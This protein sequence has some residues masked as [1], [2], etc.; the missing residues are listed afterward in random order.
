MV[1]PG[2]YTVRF[3][4]DGKTVSQPLVVK[5][6]PRDAWTQAQYQAGYDFAKKYS[7]AYGQIDRVLNNLD[8]IGKSLNAAAAA[9]AK[10]GNQTLASQIAALQKQRDEVF[11]TFTADYHNDEDSIQ[12]PGQ[13]REEV[14]RTGFGAQT[15][16]TAAQ[17]DYAGRF[18]AAYR[19]AF[20]RYNA[21]VTQIGSS[22]VK[23]MEGAV[24][25][26]P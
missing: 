11:S 18:D 15:P 22:G 10:S 4:L 9:A 6:D 20:V 19:A 12:R 21:F 26:S 17:L 2:T 24:P 23:P 16:P 7:D 14:P 5:P 3:T 25:V 1:V 13:L 8:A